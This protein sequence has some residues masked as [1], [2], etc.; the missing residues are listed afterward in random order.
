M[1][2][3][4]VEL[5]DDET[6]YGGKCFANETFKDFAG[7]FGDEDIEYCNTVKDFN[8]LLKMCGLLPLTSENYPNVEITDKA[9]N[10]LFREN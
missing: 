10:E 1:K 2:L 3:Q 4:D 8:E 7:D 9:I 5:R 6:E